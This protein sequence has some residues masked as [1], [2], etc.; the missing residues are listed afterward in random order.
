M[1]LNPQ[2]KMA[3]VVL[4]SQAAA[5]TN[6]ML[7]ETPDNPSLL[8]I[9]AQLEYLRRYAAG[10]ITDDRLKDINLGLLAAREIQGWNDALANMLHEI[11]AQIQAAAGGC[12]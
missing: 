8:S 3:L 7:S 4:L 6:T 1:T 11:S 2:N 10:Q 5:E 9:K 12:P